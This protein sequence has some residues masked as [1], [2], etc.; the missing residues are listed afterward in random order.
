MMD[1]GMFFMDVIVRNLK[2]R[3]MDGRNEF[4]IYVLILI[5]VL[6]VDIVLNIVFVVYKN[7]LKSVLFMVFWFLELK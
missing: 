4:N 1:F 7:M 2:R 3:F 6:G 5:Y